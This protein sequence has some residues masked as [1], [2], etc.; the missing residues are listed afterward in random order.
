MVGT[1]SDLCAY[2]AVKTTEAEQY[3]SSKGIPYY[4]CS[5]LEGTSVETL[6]NEACIEL[7]AKIVNHEIELSDKL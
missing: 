5:S 3:A 4:E 6:F 2:R 7:V 1:K